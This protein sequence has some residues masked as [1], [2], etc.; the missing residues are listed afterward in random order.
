[1]TT[2]ILRELRA[3]MNSGV[4]GIQREWLVRHALGVVLI[5]GVSVLALW[6]VATGSGWPFCL[7]MGWIWAWWLG[8]SH[9]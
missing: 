3:E 8:R 5:Y 2:G 6:F 4:R 9:G 1:M 7:V